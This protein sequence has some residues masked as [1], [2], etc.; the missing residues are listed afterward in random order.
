MATLPDALDVGFTSSRERRKDHSLK[1]ILYPNKAIEII[2]MLKLILPTNYNTLVS[3]T[4]SH[5]IPAMRYL[6]ILDLDLL[7]LYARFRT[8]AMLG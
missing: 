3:Q 1:S 2:E 5:S 8:P 7:L 4:M 6:S